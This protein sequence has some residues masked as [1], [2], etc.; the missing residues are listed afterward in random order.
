MS[1]ARYCLAG[2]APSPERRFGSKGPRAAARTG[3]SWV[4]DVPAQQHLVAVTRIGREP[5]GTWWHASA[6][7]EFFIEER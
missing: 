6:T 3:A 7:R 2:R 1:A 4:S 5:A